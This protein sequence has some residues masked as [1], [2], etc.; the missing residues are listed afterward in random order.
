MLNYN[1]VLLLVFF[2]TLE[3]VN[4]FQICRRG[5][6]YSIS[7]QLFDVRKKVYFRTSFR[8]RNY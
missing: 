7:I 6:A 3:T 2:I 4:R 8:K 1:D 5:G